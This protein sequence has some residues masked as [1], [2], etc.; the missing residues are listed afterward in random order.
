MKSKTSIFN[1]HK[2]FVIP[3]L[4]FILCT[5]SA[6]PVS[7]AFKVIY[8]Y[9]SSTDRT[10]GGVTFES[11]RP[12]VWSSSTSCTLKYIKK[13]QTRTLSN[14]YDGNAIIS[15]GKSVF[16]CEKNKKKTVLY[17]ADLN[18][19]SKKRIKTLGTIDYSAG[20]V[21]KYKNKVYYTNYPVE[22][23]LYCINVKSKKINELIP[24]KAPH[25]S[26]TGATQKGKYLVISDGSGAGYSYLGL[27]NLSNH[28]YK[29]ICDRPYTWHITKKY[30]YFVEK[31]T[32]NIYG[33]PMK[34]KIKR[35][36]LSNGKTKTLV[37]GLKIRNV[38]ELT[39]N[40]VKYTDA[41]GHRLNKRF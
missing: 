32:D 15:D 5:I 2:L 35:Y 6:L 28:K 41:K 38:I 33:S 37:S 22:G 8:T 1:H 21:G 20:I 40:S 30:I 12:N 24:K 31:T 36:K 25:K 26:V 3:F 9:S 23:K 16:Y 39:S 29:K 14:K 18:K 34:V 11:V 17:K 7:A 19:N 10:V 4:L 27:I 13:G